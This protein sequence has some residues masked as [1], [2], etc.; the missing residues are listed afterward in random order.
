[1]RRSSRPGAGRNLRPARSPW[2]GQCARVASPTVRP[3]AV[4][5]RHGS[6]CRSC[7]IT[8]SMVSISGSAGAARGR[9]ERHI[10]SVPDRSPTGGDR[11]ARAARARA[12]SMNASS[13]SKI[14]AWSGVSDRSRRVQACV[15][16]GASNVVK[17]GYG[18]ARQR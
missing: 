11:P 14:S 15:R 9:A 4:V 3:P 5:S 16:L 2:N 18:V 12:I 10:Q 7:S 8:S 13:L 1:M 6:S 17:N